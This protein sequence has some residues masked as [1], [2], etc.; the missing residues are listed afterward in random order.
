[1]PLPPP[2]WRFLGEGLSFKEL[3]EFWEVLAEKEGR[4]SMRQAEMN[5][6]KW[7]LQDFVR[8]QY[9][10]TLVSK[11]T[12]TPCIYFSSFRPQ[13]L[14]EVRLSGH[15]DY[16][17]GLLPEPELSFCVRY[18]RYPEFR[19]D[20]GSG[21][22]ALLGPNKPE[23]CKRYRKITGARGEDD[24]TFHRAFISLTISGS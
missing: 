10:R 20:E 3:G 23:H 11:K 14:L 18:D 21:Q 19:Q 1:M 4:P 22:G 24:T 5:L 16:R 9:T 6:W 2:G 13:E 7:L 8:S 15:H 12:L 17:H